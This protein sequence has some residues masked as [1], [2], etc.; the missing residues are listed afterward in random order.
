MAVEPWWRKPAS[1]KQLVKI[2]K[3]TPAAAMQALQ[4]LDGVKLETK[5]EV[6]IKVK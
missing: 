4:G 5:K 6:T 1:F 3:N 2:D